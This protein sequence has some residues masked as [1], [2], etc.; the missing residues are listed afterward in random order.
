MVKKAVRMS[1]SYRER[2]REIRERLRGFAVPQRRLN[3]NGPDMR[4]NDGWSAQDEER[5]WQEY[6]D[7][8]DCWWRGAS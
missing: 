4:L 3:W 7:G 6:G 8:G 2:I 1:H 5:N